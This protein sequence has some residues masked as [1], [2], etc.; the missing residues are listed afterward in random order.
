MRITLTEEMET[1]LIPLYGRAQM[2][3]LG[4][5]EDKEAERV[6]ESIAY[7]FSDLKIVKKTQIMMAMR[8]SIFDNYVRGYVAAH[9]NCT[10]IY[11][12]CGL[13]GRAAR[14]GY[15]AKQWY[16]LDFPQ[17]IEI[18][19][20]FYSESSHYHMIAS[21]VTDLDWL[22]CI[23]NKDGPTLILAEGLLMY[24]TSKEVDALLKRIQ[25]DFKESTI[26]FDAYSNFTVKQSKNHPSLKKTG[27]TIHWGVD[28]PAQIEAIGEGIRYL[29]TIYLAE[30]PVMDQLS[31]FYRMA[32]KW[33]SKWSVAKE[34]HRI[35]EVSIRKPLTVKTA[36]GK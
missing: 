5:F 12:G 30:S 4:V 19:S 31:A 24:L 35:F 21:S 17:V 14:L 13:D 8:S 27:A 18:K 1:L 29:R 11:L 34:A 9:P 28:A 22:K 7:S 33:A 6:V 36:D 3:R 26:L 10:V 20:A 16:D 15:S 32:F 23:E 2:S 25:N